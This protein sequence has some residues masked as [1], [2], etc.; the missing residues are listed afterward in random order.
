MSGLSDSLQ[1]PCGSCG[2]S[3]D[4]AH[5]CPTVPRVARSVDD[6]RVGMVVAVD[7]CIGESWKAGRITEICPQ[8]SSPGAIAAYFDG[9]GDGATHFEVRLGDEHTVVILKDPPLAPVTVLAEA[10]ERLKVA[11]IRLNSQQVLN[12]VRDLLDAIENDDGPC[13]GRCPNPD[14]GCG[15]QR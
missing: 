11:Y 15:D 13:N 2:A 14:C 1:P 12:A 10:V 6:L 5:H 8:W 9:D 7:W 4:S 3:W